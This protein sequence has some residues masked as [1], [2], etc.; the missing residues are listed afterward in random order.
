VSA[1]PTHDAWENKIHE[2]G[3]ARA[4]GFRGGLVPGVTVYSWMTHPVVAALGAAWLDHGTFS[5]RFAKPVYFGQAVVV[6][7]SVAAHSRDEVTIQVRVVNDEGE[8]CAT[9]TMGL[10]LGPLLPLPDPAAYPAA[11]LPAE[12]PPASRDYL[13]RHPV[14]G[15]PQLVLERAVLD[16]FLEKVSEKLLMYG[17]ADAPAHPGIYLEQANRALDRN[18]R[19]SPW[20]HVESHGQHLSVALVRERLETRARVKNLFQGKGHEFVELDL[21]LLAGGARPVASIRHVAIYQLRK[22][23]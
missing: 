22:A 11:A 19:V 3:L 18:V 5:V 16:G 8:V 21:L 7:A 4:F 17:E 1:T 9:A 20:I 2:D 12:R 14:L 23:G 13:E 10:P 15:T 6:R